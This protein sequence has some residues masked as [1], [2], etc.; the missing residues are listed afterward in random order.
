MSQISLCTLQEWRWEVARGHDDLA[1]AYFIACLTREQYP[2]ARMNFAPKNVSEFGSEEKPK[3]PEGLKL[4]N[5]ELQDIF[6]REMRQIRAAAG[7]RADMRGVG[8]RAA[9]RLAGI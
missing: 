8:R 1:V 4:Q 9:N 5:T 3:A 6:V 7:L 2:P